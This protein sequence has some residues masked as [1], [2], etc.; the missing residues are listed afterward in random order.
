M[1]KKYHTR[2]QDLMSHIPQEPERPRVEYTYLEYQDNSPTAEGLRRLH[3][4]IMA[5][6]RRYENLNW[7]QRLVG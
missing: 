2:R 3:P 4:V 1:K 5:F 7:R 6:E